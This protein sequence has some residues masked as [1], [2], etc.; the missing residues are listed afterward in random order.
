MSATGQPD[1]SPAPA[2]A[3]GG[4][5]RASRDAKDVRQAQAKVVLEHAMSSD[6]WHRA[7]KHGT[8]GAIL[9]ALR[10]AFTSMRSSS[11]LFFCSCSISLVLERL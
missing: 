2:D 8:A 4:D 7:S 5:A 1:E 11:V 10:A 9:D 6:L 3:Q